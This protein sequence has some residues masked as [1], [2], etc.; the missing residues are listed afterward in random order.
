LS[1]FSAALATNEFGTEDMTA[2]SSKEEGQLSA[3]LEKE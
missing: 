3:G 2:S 1:F